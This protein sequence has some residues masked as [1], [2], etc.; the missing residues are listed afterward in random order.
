[1]GSGALGPVLRIG[2]AA[3]ADVERLP[4]SGGTWM[5]PPGRYTRVAPP[6]A[7]SAS[8]GGAAAEVV[9]PPVLLR[10]CGVA[11]RVLPGRGA[12]VGAWS[13]EVWLGAS[14][15]YGSSSGAVALNGTRL[16]VVSHGLSTRAP[17]RVT[18]P[19]EVW[20]H[21][22]P[23]CR[24]GSRPG[25]VR[26]RSHGAR[27]IRTTGP[28]AYRAHRVQG[29][30]SPAHQGFGGGRRMPAARFAADAAS[31]RCGVPRGRVGRAEGEGAGDEF[32]RTC[33]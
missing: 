6:T 21:A 28:R 2:P 26:A 18:A 15:P 22:G 29:A 4:V 8:D 13:Y 10:V 27:S 19:Y 17:L 24:R 16:G 1:M 9:P 11:V 32:R 30:E 14:P 20:P 31:L 7:E 25:R 23:H 12:A 5:P 33:S 3:A